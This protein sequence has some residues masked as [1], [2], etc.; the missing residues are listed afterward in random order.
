MH[1]YV[2]SIYLKWVALILQ[3][4]DE[5]VESYVVLD[6]T[7]DMPNLED[8]LVFIDFNSGLT[9]Q[10]RGVFQDFGTGHLKFLLDLFSASVKKYVISP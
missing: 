4:S 9:S 1:T 6:D 7:N 3:G 5:K 2:K 10:C 8:Y